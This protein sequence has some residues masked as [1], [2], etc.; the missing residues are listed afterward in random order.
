MGPA[1]P[2]DRTA[3]RAAA[4]AGRGEPAEAPSAPPPASRRAPGG[5][6]PHRTGQPAH[7]DPSL[8]RL[9]RHVFSVTRGRPGGLD[10]KLGF[11]PVFSLKTV[12][13]VPQNGLWGKSERW[14]QRQ[15]RFSGLRGPDEQPRPRGKLPT[16]K[17]TSDTFLKKSC[18]VTVETKVPPAGFVTPRFFSLFVPLPFFPNLLSFFFFFL[19]S[20]L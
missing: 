2:A 9:H 8:P 13:T 10:L 7:R 17:V 5:R 4:G 6:A 14:W 20:G 16:R 19:V 1:G 3:G 11:A 18:H 15:E 12:T